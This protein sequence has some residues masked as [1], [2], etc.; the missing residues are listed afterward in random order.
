MTVQSKAFPGGAQESPES[1]LALQR[2]R[3][4]VRLREERLDLGVGQEPK[5][6]KKLIFSISLVRVNIAGWSN[7]TLQR[8]R[9]S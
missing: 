3:D 4:T 6:E 5:I 9:D 1:V 7:R 8:K 2:Q